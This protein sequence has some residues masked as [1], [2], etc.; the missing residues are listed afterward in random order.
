ML[1]LTKDKEIEFSVCLLERDAK[2]GS[3]PG[4]ED[5]RLQRSS[6]LW[7]PQQNIISESPLSPFKT[8][9]FQTIIVE[10]FQNCNRYM[11]SVHFGD[12]Y[13]SIHRLQISSL[14]QPAALNTHVSTELLP[15]VGMGKPVFSKHVLNIFK[16][17]FRILKRLQNGFSNYKTPIKLKTVFKIFFLVLK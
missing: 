3:K 6:Q 13:F 1:T 10:S 14:S 7:Q 16:T 5:R 2:E 17:V 4:S 15:R 12:Q 11:I 8:L 9:D